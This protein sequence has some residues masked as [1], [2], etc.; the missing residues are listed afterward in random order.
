MAAD[1]SN[2]E[3]EVYGQADHEVAFKKSGPPT[4]FSLNGVKEM[5]PNMQARILLDKEDRGELNLTEEL[6]KFHY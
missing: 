2:D 5:T 6:L 1:I 3:I 4:Q